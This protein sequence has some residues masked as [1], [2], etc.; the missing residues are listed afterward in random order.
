MYLVTAEGKAGGVRGG[1]ELAV[2]GLAELMVKGWRWWRA[3]GVERQRRSAT[4]QLFLLETM[5]LGPKQRVVLMRVGEERFLVGLG[6][7]GVTSVV[8]VEQGLAGDA[9]PLAAAGDGAWG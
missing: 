8:R 3:R 2:G 6:A 4:R 5:V 7:E 9:T 1:R